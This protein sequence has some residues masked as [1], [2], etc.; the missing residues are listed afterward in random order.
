MSCYYYRITNYNNVQEG[1]YRWTGC[2]G[3]VSVTGVNPLQ[4]SYV[5]ADGLYVENYAAPLDVVNMG[6]CPSNTPTPTITP[7]P[8]QTSVTPTPTQ[9]SVTPTQT[10]TP[11][12]TPVIIYRYNLRG[13]G[14]YQD[15]CNSVNMFANPANVTIYSLKEFGNL[16]VGDNVYGNEALTIPPTNPVSTISNG[17]RFIQISGTLIINVGV[18]G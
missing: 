11:T 14:Y 2:T 5:C 6:V 16:Q 8:T 15:V 4:T 13:G 3:I 7:T 1:F 9:T 18:C 12:R 10:P 17:A